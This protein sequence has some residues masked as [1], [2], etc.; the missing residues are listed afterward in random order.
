LEAGASGV[1]VVST[2]HAGIIDPVIHDKTGFLV[3][4]G[5]IDGMAKYMYQLL[6]NPELA[7]AMGKRAQEHIRENFN[8]E[9]SIKN[10]RAI[11]DQYSL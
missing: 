6:T 11:L 10:L 9:T 2:K 5:D 8:M 3:Y 7:V 4:E 1:P